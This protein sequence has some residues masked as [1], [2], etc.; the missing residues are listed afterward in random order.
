MNIQA[1]ALRGK[2]R[3]LPI[4]LIFS[5]FLLL[6]SGC[7]SLP[8]KDLAQITVDKYFKEI[9]S[10]NIDSVLTLYGEQFFKVTDR[11]QWRATLLK[12]VSTMGNYQSHKLQNF[13]VYSGESQTGFGT[14]MI[15]TFSVKYSRFSSTETFTLIK[16]PEQYKIIGH[17][18]SSRAFFLVQ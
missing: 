2:S 7:Q 15:M 6:V 17:N 4:S 13:R 8:T 18:I 12:L 16:D 11:N 9:A 3:F 14:F 1:A 10:K 5:V